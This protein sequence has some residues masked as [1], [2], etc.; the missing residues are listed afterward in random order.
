MGRILSSV[1][2]CAA[3]AGVVLTHQACGKFEAVDSVSGSLSSGSSANLD[4]RSK[5]LDIFEKNCAVCHSS[6][7]LSGTSLSYI[8][9]LNVLENSKY[10]VRG[11]P[12]SSQIYLVISNG[13]MPVGNPLSASDAAVIYAWIEALPPTPVPTA[14]PFVTPTPTPIPM[15]T[16]TPTPTP[17]IVAATFTNVKKIFTA[18]CTACHGPGGNGGV[19]LST[20]NAAVKT[21]KSK[22]AANSKLYLAVKDDFMP[23]NLAPLSAADKKLIFDWI[24]VGAPNN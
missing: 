10:V 16:P 15:A 3:A 6:S 5:A 24:Q 18:T 17:V 2:F 9:N 23:R 13:S 8:D 11:N 1:I 20:Y 12:Y 4:N 22:D 19:D 7:N 21:V 14:T